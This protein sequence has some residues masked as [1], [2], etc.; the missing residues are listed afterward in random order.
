[1]PLALLSVSDKTGLIEFAAGLIKLDWKLLASGGT[2]RALRE[3]DLH[4]EDLAEYTQSP[5]IL[6]GRVKTLHPRIYAGI[7]S[8]KTESDRDDL[9]RVQAKAIDMVVVNLYPFLETIQ[10]PGATL[11]DAIENID[12]GGVALIRAAAKNFDRVTVLTSPDDYTEIL[13]EIKLEG[14]IRETTR[15][16]LA[17]DAFRLTSNYDIEIANYLSSG[18]NE[19]TSKSFLR[20]YPATE[21]R[22]GEN[23]HQSAKLYHLSNSQPLGGTILQGKALSYNNILDL[24][25]AW[26]AVISFDKPSVCIV[27]HLCPCGIALADTQADAFR[28]SLESDPISAYGGIIAAN[29]IFEEDTAEAL[30]KLFV[31]CIIAPGFTKGALDILARRKNCRLVEMPAGTDISPTYELRSVNQGILWQERD[32]GDPE[33]SEQ[34]QTVTNRNPTTQENAAL[35]FAWIA[36]QHVKSNAIVLT[37]D[38]ATVGIGGGQPN[39]VDCVKMA[40]DRAGDKAKGAVMASDA[41]FPFSDSIELAASAGITAIIQPGGSIRDK[42]SIDRANHHNL[43][44]LFTSVRH[45]RH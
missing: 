7:L 20:E 43:A 28:L 35:H 4:V 6:N 45:F 19:E 29:K 24:D 40:I 36:C 31:E 17:L 1:M 14:A 38:E 44:M 37:Q 22:Y 8:R 27:K 10:K 2:A 26:R 39:R 42:D 30:G 41:F 34:W 3:A 13:D 16:K 11:A 33:G 18:E 5:E 9:N 25:A 23:P 32:T 15:A 12:I 21:L